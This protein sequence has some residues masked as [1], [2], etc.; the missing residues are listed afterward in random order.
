[1]LL[2]QLPPE[3]TI[4]PEEMWSSLSIN[5]LLLQKNILFDRYEFL[6]SKNVEHAKI[7]LQALNKLELVIQDKVVSGVR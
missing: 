5:E 4:V 1:M 6:L 7:F 3:K 2:D